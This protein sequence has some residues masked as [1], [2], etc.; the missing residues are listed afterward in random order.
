MQE[1]SAFEAKN[2]LYGLLD[3]VALGEEFVISRRGELVAMVTPIRQGK[4]PEKAQAAAQRIRALAR[5]LAEAA[6][7]TQAEIR[8]WRD[9]GRR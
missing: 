5:E 8:E 4:S 2:N 7:A 3:R 1:I 9:E 6:P